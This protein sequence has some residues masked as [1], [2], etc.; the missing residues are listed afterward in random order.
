MRGGFFFFKQQ[1]FKQQNLDIR[2]FLN[3]SPNTP[4]LPPPQMDREIRIEI[5]RGSE[6]SETNSVLV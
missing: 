2:N 6:I 3:P 4:P 1:N 5:K